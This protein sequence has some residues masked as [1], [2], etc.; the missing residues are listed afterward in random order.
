MS[1]HEQGETNYIEADESELEFDGDLSRFSF[2]QLRTI[3]RDLNIL[4]VVLIVYTIESLWLI[5]L[6]LIEFVPRPHRFLSLITSDFTVLHIFR[7]TVFTTLVLIHPFVLLSSYF[8]YYWGRYILPL[9][10]F[11]HIFFEPF[12]GVFALWTGVK[13]GKYYYAKNYIS[14]KSVKLEIHKRTINRRFE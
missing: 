1:K 4:R 9:S 11:M 7:I 14:Y 12:S 3:R 5:G 13:L 8:H 10:G 2:D 6:L